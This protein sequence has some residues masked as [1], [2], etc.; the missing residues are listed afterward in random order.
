VNPAQIV[1]KAKSHASH[2]KKIVLQL[3]KISPESLDRFFREQH[4]E[5]FSRTDCTMCANCCKT[6]SPVFLEKDI[7]KIA[8]YLK[9][10]P[11]EFTRKYLRRDEDYD[12][13]L[14]QVP[15]PFL[16]ENNL[17]SIYPV[18]PKACA[19]YPHTN[20]KNIQGI[21]PLTLKNALICPAVYSILENAEKELLS[22]KRK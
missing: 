1:N 10:S 3:K 21:L 6:T 8:G 20:R 11:G 2:L 22:G 17:C 12:I 5:I 4:E 7:E 15:C 19:T 18:R 14:Q 9:I 13:V 16:M